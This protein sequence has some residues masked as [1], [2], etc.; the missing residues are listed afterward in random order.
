MQSDLP[1]AG[2]RVAVIAARFGGDVVER[3]LETTVA[4]LERLGVRANDLAIHRVPG[5]FELP[6]TAL[7]VL[8][9]P[10]PPD[11]V[12]C[13]GAVIR[14]ETPHFDYV[15]SGTTDGILRVSLDTGRPVIFGVLTTD[16]LEQAWDRVDG[17]Y[18]R[19]EDFARDTVTMVKLLKSIAGASADG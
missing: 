2:L 12:V 17:R 10:H 18:R 15:A 5:S 1:G 4:E 13:L 7:A 6:V 19:G 14:G 3:L 8:R 9:G 16:T 11:A